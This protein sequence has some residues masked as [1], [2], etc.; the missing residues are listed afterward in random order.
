MEKSGKISLTSEELSSIRSGSLP[1]RIATEWGLSLKE[2]Q[3][4]INQGCYLLID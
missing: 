3:D 1:S 2:A 4:M